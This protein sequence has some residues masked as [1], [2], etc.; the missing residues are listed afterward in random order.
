MYGHLQ[1]SC[2]K[3]VDNGKYTGSDDADANIVIWRQIMFLEY[4]AMFAYIV[5]LAVNNM[6]VFSVEF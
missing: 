5:N 1:L 6:T 4:T 2:L 3:F